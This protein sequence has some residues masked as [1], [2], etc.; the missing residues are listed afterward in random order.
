MFFEI[1]ARLEFEISAAYRHSAATSSEAP[2][3]L[4]HLSPR[5][6]RNEVAGWVPV[7]R[8]GDDSFEQVSQPAVRWDA[9]VH[10]S[11]IFRGFPGFS[12]PFPFNC[13]M[14]CPFRCSVFITVPC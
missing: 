7:G 11:S 1:S 13:L 2:I 5:H 4:I 10:S 6:R 12:R 9:K 3:S 14:K 8:G